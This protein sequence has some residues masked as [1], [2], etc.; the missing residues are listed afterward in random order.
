[1]NA[2]RVALLTDSCADI[3]ANLVKKYD[4]HV[5]PLRLLFSDGEY[6]DGVSITA[7][8]VYR[9]LPQEIPKTSLPSGE[10]IERTFRMIREKGYE[11]VIAINFSGGLSGTANMVR[12]LGEQFVGLEVAAFD[13]LSGSLGTGMTV[14]QAAR[15]LEEGHTFVQVCRAI[16]RIIGT[17]TVFFCI[18]TLEYLQK[19]GRIGLITSF[20]GSLL[21]IKPIISFAPSGELVNVAKVRGRKLAIQKMVGMAA[22][23]VG[24]GAAFNLAVAHGDSLAEF[25][26]IRALAKAEM[27]GFR[28][29]FEGEIDGTLGVYTGPHLLGVGVQLLPDGLFQEE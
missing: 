26:E 23:L 20:A 4:I 21:N 17:T 1:M 7:K 10:R 27:P 8:E 12:L 6:E 15:W 2:Q 18:D 16:P 25:K 28:S 11:K 14:L 22:E 24:E 29:L 13:T 19:G 5:V 9:R 3:P